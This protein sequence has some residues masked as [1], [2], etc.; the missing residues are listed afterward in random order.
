MSWDQGE[1]VYL[2]DDD[3]VCNIVGSS[4]QRGN[5]KQCWVRYSGRQW[6]GRCQM[7]NCGG[8]AQV[9]SHIWVKGLRQAFIIPACQACNMARE[10]QWDPFTGRP[11]VWAS[12]KQNAAAV[13]IDRDGRY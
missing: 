1:I 5:H 12:V 10:L 9:G 3:E 11:R 8:A 13:R 2:D 4:R 7:V 6:P